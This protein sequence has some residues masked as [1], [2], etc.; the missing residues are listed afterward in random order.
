MATT[1]VRTHMQ[2]K[3]KLLIVAPLPCVLR[4][5]DRDR[6]RSLEIFL[7]L[8]NQ[9]DQEHIFEADLLAQ[10]PIHKGDEENAR[11]ALVNTHYQTPRRNLCIVGRTHKGLLHLQRDLLRERAFRRRIGLSRER[12]LRLLTY[13]VM[14]DQSISMEPRVERL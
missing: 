14:R 2:S 13:N 1:R 7:G 9:L 4:R 8:L 5:I 3:A 10:P 12:Q 11:N 6:N